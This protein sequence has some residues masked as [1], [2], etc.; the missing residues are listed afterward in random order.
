MERTWENELY[1]TLASYCE[2]GNPGMAQDYLVKYM[3]DTGAIWQQ[4]GLHGQF[5]MRIHRVADEIN[6]D[7]ELEMRL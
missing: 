3:K 5:M 6:R 7:Y 1:D 2:A 4:S